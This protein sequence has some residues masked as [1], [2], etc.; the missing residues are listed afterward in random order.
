MTAARITRSVLCAAL[1]SALVWQAGAR[2]ATTD[3]FGLHATVGPD[4]FVIEMRMPILCLR[5]QGAIPGFIVATAHL[6][7]CAGCGAAP[8][9]RS[10]S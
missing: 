3:L 5:L 2:A 7:T 4:H 6:L 8:R 1:A 10:W 9:T